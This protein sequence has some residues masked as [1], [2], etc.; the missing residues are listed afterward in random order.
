MND[1]I[2]H[3]ILKQPHRR[4]H[5]TNINDLILFN[6]MYLLPGVNNGRGEMDGRRKGNLEKELLF[7]VGKIR[8]FETNA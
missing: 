8:E 2:F 5:T 1:N 6:E 3:G 4:N 7:P